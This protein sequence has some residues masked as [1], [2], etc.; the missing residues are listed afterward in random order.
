MSTESAQLAQHLG[1]AR[2]L[3]RA[4]VGDVHLAEDVSQDALTDLLTRPAATLRNPR[5]YLVAAVRHGASR[6]RKASERR[7]AREREVAR[8]ERV[9][10]SAAIV[11][12]M[13]LHRRLVEALL[14]LDEPVRETLVLR[15]FESLAPR[16]IAQR[17]GLPV[18]TVRTRIKRALKKLRRG[19]D[20]SFCGDRRAWSAALAPLASPEA[21]GM[22]AGASAKTTIAGMLVMSSKTKIACVTAL[23]VVLGSFW[24]LRAPR[25]S[26]P[27]VLEVLGPDQAAELSAVERKTVATDTQGHPRP[28][29]ER[30]AVAPA[31]RLGSAVLEFVWKHDGSPATDLLVSCEAM[32]ENGGNPFKARTDQRGIL[33]LDGL[34]PGSYFLSGRLLQH[35]LVINTSG[36]TRERIELEAGLRI[37]GIVIDRDGRGVPDAGVWVKNFADVNDEEPRLAATSGPDGTFDGA[38][39]WGGYVW[40]R[41]RG[42]MPSQCDRGALGGELKLRLVLGDAGCGV[43]GVVL[44]VDGRPTPHARLTILDQT[45]PKTFATPIVLRTDPLGAFETG[46]LVAGKHL[47]VAQADGH[48][49]TP[50]WFTASPDAEQV[51]QVR[52]HLGATLVGSVLTPGGQPMHARLQARPAWTGQAGF[53]ALRAIRHLCS[54]RG[55]NADGRYRLEHVSIGPVTLEATTAHGTLVPKELVLEEGALQNHDF[56]LNPHTEIH[57]RLIDARGAPIASWNVMANPVGGRM[58]HG[59]NTDEL[60][61]FVLQGLDAQEY[62]VTASPPGANFLWPW[63]S[64]DRVRPGPGVLLL[65]AEHQPKDGGRFTGQVV[66]AGGEKD[67]RTWLTAYV[68]NQR[69]TLEVRLDADGMFETDPL[70]PGRYGIAVSVERQGAVGLGT[71]DLHAR[72][73]VNLG[74]IRVPASGTLEIHLGTPTGGVLEPLK[75]LLKDTVGNFGTEFERMGDGGWR[76]EPLPAGTYTLS[77]WGESFARIRQQVELLPGQATPIGV[78]AEPATPVRFELRCADRA[79]EGVSD[80]VLKVFDVAGEKVVTHTVVAEDGAAFTFGFATGS[81]TYEV[82]AGHHS[83]P[84]RGMFEVSGGETHHVEVPMIG[85]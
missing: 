29:R 59:A 10:S 4:L 55:V 30:V 35:E 7:L 28:G 77:A 54:V 83:E 34:E 25:P 9:H 76:S 36:V 14:V 75:L 69:R 82:R 26:A 22:T 68:E 40:A 72:E 21:L 20:D 61:E 49:A 18:E 45:N 52:L 12:A 38:V 17:M 13:E 78:V 62:S 39:D 58:G 50:L 74:A 6:S 15:Y 60:G 24:A 51:L 33:M 85:N 47:L 3:A 64:A 16:D 5:A 46:E 63:A 80:L 31:D 79:G 43:N 67:S 53:E 37:T 44:G 1:F 66:G 42:H 56:V 81:Y 71:R 70:P 32:T 23:A 19:L 73:L 65:R 8:P 27:A 57:G 2:R 84:V 11:E 48:A 41:K